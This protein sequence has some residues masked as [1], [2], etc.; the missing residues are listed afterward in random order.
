MAGRPSLTRDS[1]LSILAD[2]RPMS[3]REIIKETGLSPS[4]V[5]NGLQRC[6][7]GGMFSGRRLRYMRLRRSS[8]VVQGFLSLPGPIIST[9]EKRKCR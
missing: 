4:A 8:K 1:I 6:W 7:Q 5:W 2:D 9:C 3:H